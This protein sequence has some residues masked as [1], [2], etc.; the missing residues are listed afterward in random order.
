MAARAGAGVDQRLTVE[1]S[2]V[3]L[4]VVNGDADRLVNLDYFDSVAYAGLWEGRCHR[5]AGAVMHLSGTR[6]NASI[7]SSSASCSI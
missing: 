2:T 5:V 1:Q 4:A 3:P 6:R 7:L